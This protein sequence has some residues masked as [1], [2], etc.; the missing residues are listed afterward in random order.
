MN[1]TYIEKIEARCKDCYRCLR[2]CPVKAI[3]V[4]RDEKT[5]E[6]H[7]DILEERCILDGKC[8]TVCPQRAKRP[9]Q[10]VRAVKSLISRGFSV[11]A[12]VAPSFAA[13]LPLRSPLVLP[14]LLRK[15]GFA[16]VGETSAGALAVTK[17][18]VEHWK[19]RSGPMI[20]SSCPAVV[21]LVERHYPEALASLAPV[22]S[23][24]VA[25]ARMI[26]KE[27]PQS[28]VV[29]LG[30]CVAKKEEADRPDSALSIDAVLTFDELWAWARNE[31]VDVGSLEETSFDGPSPG[32]ARLFPAEGG[33]LRTAGIMEP[34]VPENVISATGIENCIEMIKYVLSHPK[35]RLLV[36]LMACT[37]GCVNGPGSAVELDLFAR[38]QRVIEYFRAAKHTQHAGNLPELDPGELYRSYKD[39]KVREEPVAEAEIREVLAL[40]G[41][42]SPQDELNCG[43]CGFETCRDKALACLRGLADPTM[44]I[45]YM[46]RKA[47]SMANLVVFASPNP[48]FVMTY[49]GII[50]DANPAAEALTGKSRQELAGQA[51]SEILGRELVYKA[52]N[53]AD[54]GVLR[55]NLTT[56]ERYFEVTAYKEPDQR[57]LVLILADRTAEKE[58]QAKYQMLRDETLQKVEEVIKKQME[59]AQKIAGLLGETTAETKGSLS[60][61]VKTLKQAGE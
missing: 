2:E 41:K 50:Q 35:D 30:P 56:G 60:Q 32:E 16:Y 15:L 20:T 37:G 54:T 51:A 21:N 7:A 19:C 9:V 42:Y 34:F 4:R 48:I 25:H 52:R 43:A 11:A 29:F 61:L 46:R 31:G 23:P 40:T 39:K 6:V 49:E 28:K 57:S 5:S 14:T 1:M 26:K 22:V 27:M 59:V 24:A 55:E 8:V 38:R 36:E 33:L 58:Q 17:A 10:S 53:A 44:C 47:E 45:P 12:S 13:H 3:R 18:H